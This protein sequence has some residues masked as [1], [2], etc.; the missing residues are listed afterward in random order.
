[1]KFQHHESPPITRKLIGQRVLRS[2]D[3]R[4]VTGRGHYLADISLPGQLHASF[5]RSPAAHARI[6]TIDLSEAVAAPGVHLVWTGH[7]V[8]EFCSGIEAQFTAEGCELITMPLMA[9]DVVR[10][11][12]EPIAVVIADSRA[13]AEDACD[14]VSIDFEDLEVVLDPRVSIEGGSVANG[15]RP[16]NV[17]LRGRASFGDVDTAFDTAEHVVS[18]L[19]HP[20]RVSA[21]PMETRGCLA[22]F[23]WS[24]QKVKLWTSTQMPHYVKLCLGLY[25][26]FSEA[27]C[28]VLSP[29]TGGGF[30][31]KA[32]IYPEELIMPLVS[33]E[34]GTPVKW[35]EDRR[36]NLLAGAHAHEQYVTISYALDANGR[37]S[38]V[39]TH[40]LVDGG[41]YHAPPQTM[42]VE[43]WCTAAVTP[44]GVYDIPA[45]EYVYEG[46]VTNKCPVGAYRGVGYMA[47]TLARECLI[48]DAA[49]T[50]GL[51]PF[52]IR[53]RNVV[54]DFPWVNPQ[55]IA[56]E[57]GSWARC[58]DKL[59]EMVDYPA[60]LERQAKA[61]ERGV[62]LGLGI[63][64]F[65]ESSGESTG[66]I[67]A[68]GMNET[69]H[70]TATVKMDPT[71]SVLVTT[72][73]NSQG[74]GQET[75]IAQ[76]ASDVLGVP[77]EAI[78]VD[79][80]TSTK[81]AY[82]SGT[83]GSRGAVI[84]GGC[85]NRAAAE[86]RE[87]L[88]TVAAQM[89]GVAKEDIELSDG[90][91]TSKSDPEAK[92][93]IA[94]VAM[95]A[96]YDSNA[97]PDGFDTRLEA[98]RAWDTSR[99]MFSNGGHAMIV[100]L[101]PETGIVN[102]ERVYSVEDCGVMINPMIVEGQIRGGV[103]QGIGLSLLEQLVYDNAGNLT[104][105]SFLDYQ[106][107]TMDVSPP[108]E[109][110]HLE[111]PSAISAAGIKGMGESGLIAAPAAVL[112]AVNDA[113]SAFGATLHELPATPER[114]FN[115]IQ[116]ITT[117]EE[118]Q[119]WRQLWD[120]AGVTA[121]DPGDATV[122]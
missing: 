103:V 48:D 51:S 25:L 30:G 13:I 73:I 79:A 98:T 62:Y 56:Y 71:G 50:L 38:A 26:G 113:L 111:T 69:Y 52:E 28:E 33:R 46:A 85:V 58:I 65:V 74:Q 29:D 82:G 112:N 11:V 36:E 116:G 24:T 47:G 92:M 34:L 100:E 1:M 120:R 84:A 42:A 39:R 10:Y 87:Q 104:T 54:R 114:V 109:I 81:G 3:V 75:T 99:P 78:T 12:G 5:V 35:V 86:V 83:V 40:A 105:T 77:F 17:G 121:A 63:S 4:L 110:Q 122:V 76:I 49:R 67:Q 80:G 32:H 119:P 102:V 7:D 16:D 70:D 43:S 64:V 68:H 96:H 108:F 9:R 20:G 117:P 37:I 27:R 45:A 88:I 61:R 57:E 94:D 2:E 59:E 90:Q 66:M 23:D 95:A 18:G 21:S 31:Q 15:E 44:T 55:G 8:E 97:W 101:D 72:G 6:A 89:L 93:E 115:A 107:P 22:S 53:R 60:F 106:V 41:A 19:F 14:L 91:V 118:P